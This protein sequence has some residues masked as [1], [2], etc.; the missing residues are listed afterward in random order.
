M[1]LTRREFARLSGMAAAAAAAGCATAPAVRKNEHDF[2]WAY[3]IHLGTN[4]MC[5]CVPSSWGNF[6]K[7]QLPGFAPST[8]LRCDDAMWREAVDAHVKA[9][10]NTLVI[11]IAEGLVYPSHP[12]LAIKGSWSVDKLR[13]EIARLRGMGVEVLPK[14]NFSATHDIWLQDYSRM[15]S[16]PEYYK[17]CEDLIR[18]V[19]EIF[20]HPRLIHLG[21][22]EE[23]WENQ[24]KYQYVVI[25][26]GE[27][28]WH[29]FLWFVSTVEKLGMQAW[30]WTDCNRK[31]PEVFYKRMPK[32]VVQSNWYYGVNFTGKDEPK[33]MKD[34]EKQRLQY[35]IDFSKAGFQQM[36][37]GSNWYRDG[38]FPALARFCREN[39]SKQSLRGMLMAPW[40]KTVPENRAKLLSSAAEM[41]EAIKGA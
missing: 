5:D 19:Y 14:L 10:M 37:C 22:D 34:S 36:P 26:Q 11:G 17:V 39:I 9:G 4:T 7:E 31:H 6:K 27:L 3:L 13:A 35:Y 33:D 15:V 41:A 38:N 29:D 21:Y 20:D 16:T 12:E 8:T 2:L 40:F 18:D 24:C 25:R 32:S 1:N 28:W 30:I 23:N